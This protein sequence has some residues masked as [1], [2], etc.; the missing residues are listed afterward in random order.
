MVW[1]GRVIAQRTQSAFRFERCSTIRV[2]PVD[3]CSTNGD[4]SG[5]PVRVLRSNAANAPL[6]R[7]RTL[8]VVCGVLCDRPVLHH[9]FGPWQSSYSRAERERAALARWYRDDVGCLTC[10][11]AGDVALLHL[12][13]GPSNGRRSARSGA[14]RFRDDV[15]CRRF[16]AIRTSPSA[17]PAHI[18]CSARSC[19]SPDPGWAAAITGP[20]VTGLSFHR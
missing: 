12:A 5:P 20:G 8:L 3:P 6:L 18:S 19:A 4:L 13:C 11:R 16:A 15:R 2:F 10:Y 14:K 1:L 7:R 17:S 9:S